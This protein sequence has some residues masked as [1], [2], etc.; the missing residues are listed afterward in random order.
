MAMPTKKRLSSQTG[1]K[2]DNSIKLKIPKHNGFHKLCTNNKFK[3]KKKIS[4]S[5]FHRIDF[6]IS[7]GELSNAYTTLSQWHDLL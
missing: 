2:I 1:V 4:N 6:S 7:F 5:V 3:L